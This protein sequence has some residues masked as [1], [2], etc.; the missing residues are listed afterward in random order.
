VDACQLQI[1]VLQHQVGAL[2]TI[3]HELQATNALYHE[4]L[5]RAAEQIALL[6][7]ALWS[8]RRER[9][10]PDPSQQTL[11]L[12]QTLGNPSPN[13][14]VA[15]PAAE[16]ELNDS[17]DEPPPA[18]QNSG[19]T[20]RRRKRLVFPQFL[21]RR[22][23]DHPLPEAERPCGC[24]GQERVVIQEHVSEQLEIEPAQVYVA[25]H[26]RYTY[27]CAKCR[28]GEQMVTPPKPPQVLEKGLLG[29]SIAAYVLEL[30]YV[31]HV[32]LYR[33]QEMLLGPL[34]QWLSR[35]LLCGLMHRTAEALHPLCRLIRQRVLLS[36]LVHVDE[37]TMRLLDRNFDKAL[38]AYYWA[39]A[40]ELDYP[41]VF[42]DFQDNRGQDGPAGIL[43]DYR[44]YLQTDGYSVYSALVRESRGRLIDVACWAHVRRKF[45][46]ARFTTGHVLLHEALGGIQQLYDVEDR[47]RSWSPENRL[48]LRIAEGLPIVDRLQA[49][50]DAVAPE[51]RPSSK[52]AEAVGYA[53]NRW[54]ALRR[55]TTDGRIP[56][57]TNEIE[58]QFRVVALARKNS[59]FVG[60][61]DGGHTA[62]RLYTIVQSAKRHN[63]ALSPYLNDVL[64]RLPLLTDA[65]TPLDSLLPDQWAKEHPQH[66]LAERQQESRE[67]RLRRD[68]RRAVRRSG[69]A[70]Q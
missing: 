4:Q 16:Q 48:Q 68:R 52:L 41:Y 3:N 24:C 2:Q 58:R 34:K 32:P 49:R 7:K 28:H 22:R 27:A 8:P 18:A 29:P 35:P 56:V 61:R 47:A 70:A 31:R 67:A 14:T 51:L 19:P 45:D 64:Q 50:F 20:R 42:Y 33:Q 25:Q 69:P 30:K 57:D 10:L 26:V 53:R 38:T 5:A 39:Y 40:G 9:Y 43:A 62:A 37:S 55:F 1:A 15:E 21:E 12:P 65:G 13:D 66:V 6:T 36:F 17:D 63:L 44:G 60:S 11:F 23:H 54:E 59:L 46:E